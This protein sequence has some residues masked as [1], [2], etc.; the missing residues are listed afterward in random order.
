MDTIT[1]EPLRSLLAFICHLL[2]LC[3]KCPQFFNE[4]EVAIMAELRPIQSNVSALIIKEGLIMCFNFIGQIFN[5]RFS[6]TRCFL[7]SPITVDSLIFGVLC[8]AYRP[9]SQRQSWLSVS[10]SVTLGTRWHV[11]DLP[12]GCCLLNC[13][14]FP[15]VEKILKSFPSQISSICSR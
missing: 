7:S 9:L 4:L 11:T 15:C 13:S 5:T 2:Y 12:P 6:N 3:M 8:S 10:E 1:F 14:R